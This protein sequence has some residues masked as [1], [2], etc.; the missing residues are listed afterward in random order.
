MEKLRDFYRGATKRWKVTFPFDISGGAVLFRMAQDIHAD[1]PDLEI[2]GTLDAADGTGQIFGATMEISAAASRP[3]TP[4]DYHCE[5]EL[6][7]PTGDVSIFGEQRIKL[8]PGV[9]KAAW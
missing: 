5:H 2:A 6:D 7:M 9:P 4:G 3:L 1:V 8:L